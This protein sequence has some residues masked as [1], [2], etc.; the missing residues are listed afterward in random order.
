[1]SAEGKKHI[2]GSREGENGNSLSAANCKTVHHMLLVTW[3]FR[4]TPEKH[5]QTWSFRENTATTQ[6]LFIKNNLKEKKKKQKKKKK[7][8]MKKKKEKSA[9]RG[10]VLGGQYGPPTVHRCCKSLNPHLSS[11]QGAVDPHT[12]TP[13]W[14]FLILWHFTEWQAGLNE[15]DTMIWFMKSGG[16]LGRRQCSFRYQTAY[17]F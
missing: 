15:P 11:S 2:V 5:H 6:I 1:M 3:S 8:G 7:V 9:L 12:H 13:E 17:G 16:S 10:E 4:E 14:H